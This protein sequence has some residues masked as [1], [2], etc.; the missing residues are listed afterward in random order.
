ME[1]GD[2]IVDLV[3]NVAVLFVMMVPGIVMK[4]TKLVPDGF[5][6]GIS[7]LVLY[8]AQP[9]LI[10]SAYVNCKSH[11]ADIWQNILVVFLL[12]ILAHVI[13]AVVAMNLFKWAE[14]GKRRILRMV[15]IFAN[16]AFMG[17]PLIEAMLGAEAAIYASIY[18]ITFNLFLW[19]LGVF[20]C[21]RNSDEDVDGD[22]DADLDDDLKVIKTHVK[23]KEISITKVLLHPV[24]IASVIGIIILVTG[25]NA[26]IG[27]NL[28]SETPNILIE[29][30]VNCITMIKGLV[31]PLSMVVIGIR[32]ADVDFR[33][34]FRDL[35]MYLFLGLRHFALPLVFVGISKLLILIGAPISNECLIVATILAATPAASSA[36]MFAEKYDCDAGYAS[37]LVTVSTILSILTMPLIV[38]VAQL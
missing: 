19:T 17:I 25:A 14:D 32:L 38:I 12:S 4:L 37:K 34:L 1:I 20:L 22:G 28:A 26:A 24:T 21:T 16:A 9:I 29:F 27:S 36:T 30:F 23:S 35:N 8:I 5:G 3:F 31:A 6:K 13:F 18:N 11:F 2:L 7:N 33:G 10:V 15:T